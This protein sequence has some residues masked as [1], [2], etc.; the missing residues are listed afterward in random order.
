MAHIQKTISNI[1]YF[2]FTLFQYRHTVDVS[3]DHQE[4]HGHTG[5]SI[6]EKYLAVTDESKE[7]VVGLLDGSSQTLI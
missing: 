4:L 1:H 2:V 3:G 7:W 6:T 5:L